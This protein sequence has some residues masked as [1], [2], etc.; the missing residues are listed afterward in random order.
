MALSALEAV[1]QWDDPDEDTFP[2]WDKNRFDGNMRRAAVDMLGDEFAAELAM[3]GIPRAFGVDLSGRLGLHNL[4]FMGMTDDGKSTVW[5]FV[6]QLGGAPLAVVT[7]WERGFR[8]A[9][10]GDMQRAAESAAPKAIRDVM[11][12]VRAGTRGLETFQGT[13]F[14]AP[15]EFDAMDHFIKMMGFSPR[16]TAELYEKRSA[17]MSYDRRKGREKTKVLNRLMNGNMTWEEVNEWN[18]KNPD[19]RVTMA[20]YIRRKNQQR[21]DELFTDKGY[22]RDIR[23]PSISEQARF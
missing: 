15:E 4:M 3:R 9:M 21:K 2:F 22:P 19:Y 1:W 8:Y 7:Q 11:G 18:A 6:E 13:Q 12:S 14:M 20:D 23:K 17:Q 16:Q 10:N 5:K